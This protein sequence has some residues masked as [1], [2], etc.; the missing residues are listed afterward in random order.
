M[1]GG[2]GRGRSFKGRRL[3]QIS[4]DRRDA[5]SKEALI[6]G[7]GGGAVIRRFTVTKIDNYLLTE[8]E[9]FTGKQ[10]T[11][12]TEHLRLISCLLYGFLLCLCKPVSSP[13]HYGRVI[14]NLSARYM[15]LQEQAI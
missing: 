13:W 12:K 4:A 9:V 10:K 15:Q 6:R 3:F 1:G 14:A 2:S 8:S 7:G 11:V 5:Y